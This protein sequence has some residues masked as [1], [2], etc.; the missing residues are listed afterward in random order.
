MWRD[1]RFL[2][3]RFAYHLKKGLV[4]INGQAYHIPRELLSVYSLRRANTY[5]PD[6]VAFLRKWLQPGDVVVDVGANIGLLT[7]EAARQVAPG[8]RVYAFEPNPYV[9]SSLVNMVRLNGEQEVVISLPVALSDKQTL[10]EFFVSRDPSPTMAKSGFSGQS[11]DVKVWVLADQL[12]AQLGKLE[13]CT[14]IKIDVEGAEVTVL[15]GAHK[16][17]D[18]HSPI[19]S[20]EVHGLYF[21]NPREVAEPVFAFFADRGYQAWNLA[22]RAQESLEAF[23]ADTGEPGVDPVSGK[24]FSTLGYG[25]LIFA[26]GQDQERLKLILAE[27]EASA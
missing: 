8:G 19:V 25:H 5:E 12:D 3:T 14:L 17:F 1:L 22:K 18:L 13:R 23:L 16:F 21:K 15:N 26:K 4:E 10:T 7:V 11:G 20:I 9:F 27:L 24:T 6:H 2:V